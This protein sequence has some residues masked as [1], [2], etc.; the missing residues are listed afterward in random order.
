MLQAANERVRQAA[1][2]V[3]LLADGVYICAKHEEFPAVRSAL[4]DTTRRV[5]AVAARGVRWWDSADADAYWYAYEEVANRLEI[6]RIFTL[7]PGEDKGTL[8]RVLARHT[9]AGMRAFVIQAAQVPTHHIRPVVIFDEY[10]VHR[11]GNDREATDEN[12]CVEFSA[13]P[14]DVAA[15]EETFRVILNLASEPGGIA[16]KRV[17]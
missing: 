6:I 8:R 2:E 13:R 14:S 1:E 4:A 7:Q 9:K 5:R 17:N 3:G 10:L 16:P 15:A 11:T 12:V